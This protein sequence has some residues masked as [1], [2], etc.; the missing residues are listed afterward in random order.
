MPT[1]LLLR[2]IC[3]AANHRETFGKL[4]SPL[5]WEGR[6]GCDW[7]SWASQNALPLPWIPAFAGMTN[8]GNGFLEERAT[9]NFIILLPFALSLS[10]GK[11][12]IPSGLSLR[13]T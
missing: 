1:G 12:Q 9:F 7:V 10:K 4:L 6:D 13:L 11:R 3:Q 2:P 8:L 5:M